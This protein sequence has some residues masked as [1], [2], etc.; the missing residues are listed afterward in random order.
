VI[1]AGIAV[2]AIF[3]GLTLLIIVIFVIWWKRQKRQL[4]QLPSAYNVEALVRISYVI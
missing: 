1:G 3:V 2:M 4:K